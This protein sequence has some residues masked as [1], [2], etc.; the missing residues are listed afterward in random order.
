MNWSRTIF[1]CIIIHVQIQRQ[2]HFFLQIESVFFS[3]SSGISVTLTLNVLNIPMMIIG[4]SMFWCVYAIWVIM[5]YGYTR[6][7]QN[8][9]SHSKKPQYRI[10]CFGIANMCCVAF[11]HNHCFLIWVLSRL[12]RWTNIQSK[13]GNV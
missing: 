13:I 4:M 6:Y 3:L 10:A 9:E 2:L 7:K 8:N 12:T 11:L 1:A 5:L